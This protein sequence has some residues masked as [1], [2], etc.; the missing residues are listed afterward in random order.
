MHRDIPRYVRMLEDGRL[1]V[2]IVVTAE[3]G[4]DEIN[5]ALEACREHRAVTG[6]VVPDRA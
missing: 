5:A 6:V 2:S 3:F 4:L 1:D